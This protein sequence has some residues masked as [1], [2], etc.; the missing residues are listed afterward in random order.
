MNT[1]RFMKKAISLMLALVLVAG[2]LP[3]T[4]LAAGAGTV[5]MS[6]SY[7]G[8]YIDGTNGPVA[9]VPVSLEELAGID[10]DTYG[11]S[12]Y[13]YDGDGDGDNDITA[14]HLYIYTH[15][16]ILGLD[17]SEVRVSGGSGS[18]FFEGGLFGFTDCN[19]S[20]YMNG[21]YPELSP[22]WGATADNL[23][24]ESGDFFDIAAYTS[25]AFYSDSATGFHYFADSNGDITHRYTADAA[26]ETTVRLVRTGGGF[27]SEKTL[28]A[29]EDYEVFYGTSFGNSTGSVQTGSDGCAAITFPSAGTWYLWCD[30]GYGA[31]NPMD[32]VSA[33][34][35]ATVTVTAKEEP[36]QPSEQPRQPQIVTS[37]LNATMAKLA[38]TVTAPAFG[39]NAG[40]WTVLSL[41]RGGYYAKDNAYFTDYYDRIVATVNEKAGSVNMNGALHASK[42]TDNS[43][44][45]LALSAIGKNATAVG[46]WNLT[47]PYSNFNWIKNQGLNGVI[48]ALIA[49]DSNDYYTTD[50]TI[51][52]QCVDFILNKQLQDGGWALSGTTANADITGMALQALYPYRSKSGVAAAAEA[53]IACLS[54]MQLET[55][56]FLYGEGETSES[57]VQVIVALSTWGIN[58]DTDIRFIKN[59]RSVVDNLLSYY[60]EEE[61]M[62]AHQGTVSNDM[63]TDQACYALVA[64]DRLLKGK[65]ALYDFSDVTFDVPDSGSEDN[66]EDSGEEDNQT[67]GGE[68]GGN[69][70]GGS[71]EKNGI[72][73]AIGLPAEIENAVGTT[74][75]AVISVDNWDN[76][77]GFK[78]VDFVMPV[79]DGLKLTGVTSGDRI[80][81]GEV[82]WN[83]DE[84][85][86]LRCVYFD[87]NKHTDLTISGTQFPVELFT[88]SFEILEKLEEENLTISI[89][90]MSIK[91]SSDSSDEDAMVVVNV[92][93][94]TNPDGGTTGGGSGNVGI[95]T[96]ISFSAVTLYTGDD[97]DLIPGSKKAVAVTVTGIAENAALSYNDG[98]S[99]ITFLY[100]KAIS[101]KIGVS[102]Y[103]ALVDASLAME[104]FINRNNFT[105]G[106]VTPDE[107]IFGDANGDGIIN[108]QD[109]LAAVDAWLRKGDAPDD[110][111]VL[112]LN[113][114]G[115]S[116]INTF[117]ALGIVEAFV[118]SSTYGVVTKAA[119]QFTKA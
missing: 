86:N 100:N 25:W 89:E 4:V 96:G 65:T 77:A 107:L 31:E 80:F 39:T 103:V 57:A 32:I 28:N 1:M 119:T 84:S 79:P 47:A 60:L 109:A 58:P 27:G 63:A 43:R 9:Y 114:N 40:E 29:V 99:Q 19:L 37:V 108:A 36:E 15:E 45:I 38:A 11:L 8:A 68:S 49:L 110:L 64:Y 12:D 112:T 46:K 88:I 44:L 91:R 115:D 10:L 51:R 82:S 105:I 54:G 94:V 106:A 104:Q 20:Y 76:T 74:F 52:Q 33:P 48:F 92:E 67:P 23:V 81:G 73:A 55:G 26:Q 98:T 14:L 18:I 56:G 13:K 118:N 34:A 2:L 50:S 16:Q 75:N 30:G 72:N 116:R 66:S 59:G 22:G 17:W 61:A 111:D 5:Y 87:A 117:D 71:T 93:P 42:S 24:L 35:Y 95:V 97:V 7:D 83:V 70:S 101:E 85:N 62:F 53:A 78:L 90:G 113:I 3:A 6:I 41:A 102:T 69:G 21:E